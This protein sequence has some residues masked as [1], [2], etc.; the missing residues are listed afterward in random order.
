MSEDRP[1]E[2]GF[3]ELSQFFIGDNTMNDTV[4]RI[5]ELAVAS[6]GAAYAGVTMLVNGTV[7]TGVFTD[8]KS[9]E[10]DQAQYDTG[11]GP[12]LDAFRTG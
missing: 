8:P 11:E 9:P 2:A 5:A 4:R 6:T 12:C 3:A 1:I 10:I 7:E